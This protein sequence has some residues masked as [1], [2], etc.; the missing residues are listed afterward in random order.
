MGKAL[1]NRVD[2]VTWL[3]DV[4]QSLSLTT[5][6][7]QDGKGGHGG[8]DGAQQHGLSLTKVG[9]ATAAYECLTGHQR[10]P[11]LRP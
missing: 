8:R 1:N 10:K 11:T 3:G 7:Q 4:S 9:L 5:P 6:V 2:Q